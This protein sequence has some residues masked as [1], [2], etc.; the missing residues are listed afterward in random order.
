MES[1]RLVFHGWG[2]VCV[3]EIVT[4]CRPRKG[5]VELGNTDMESNQE[6][7]PCSLM[8]KNLSFTTTSFIASLTFHISCQNNSWRLWQS[9]E[10][11]HVKHRAQSILISWQMFIIIIAMIDMI[12]VV[13]LSLESEIPLCPWGFLV[14]SLR[15]FDT[16]K[17]KISFQISYSLFW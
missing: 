6:G 17:H 1:M 4:L 13:F 9:A 15:S 12:V 7:R 3:T 2:G 5:E 11:V 10:I 8:P 14:K 16:Q